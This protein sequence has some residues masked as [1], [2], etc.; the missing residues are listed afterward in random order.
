MMPMDGDVD[1]RQASPTSVQRVARL[2]DGQW[3]QADDE[4]A[5]EVP[6]ALEYNGVSH[7]VL[8]ATPA[9]LEQFALGFSLSEGIIGSV[10]EFHG[11]DV[12]HAANGVTVHID[13]GAAAFA[14][15]KERRRSLTGRTGCGLCGVDSLDQAIRP[16]APLPP[17]Q[18]LAASAIRRA[19]A[20][21]K[22]MQPLNRVTGATH[23]ALWCDSAGS[24]HRAFEDVGRHNALDKLIG[25]L[26]QSHKARP[27]GFALITSR[28][29]VEMVQKAATAGMGALVAISAPT[30]LAARMAQQCGMIL[31]AF[32]RGADFVAYANG[33]HIELD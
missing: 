3:S 2:R 21:V 22:Q 7:A 19:L 23:A 9:D 27:A 18:A 14:R 31:V 20:G 26:A 1:E 33:H 13:I 15:L 5:E 10:R 4:L 8:M 11:A 25:A 17:G 12:E 6:V 32:A 29:S 28:A 24:V 16:V 30:A